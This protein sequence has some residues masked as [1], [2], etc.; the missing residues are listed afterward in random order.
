[1]AITK[2]Q[3]PTLRHNVANSGRVAWLELFFDL[4]YVAALI[5]LGDQLSDDVSWSGATRFVGMFVVLLWTWTGTSAF[6]N[7]FV[8]YAVVQL[9]LDSVQ[10][11][12]VGKLALVAVAPIENRWSW[13]VVA[14]VPA[15][16]PLLIMYVRTRNL[17][18]AS[19]RLSNLYMASFGTGVAIWIVSLLVPTPARF[20]FWAVALGIE[21]LAPIVDARRADPPPTHVEHFAERYALFTIIV[22]GESFVK[23]LSELAEVGVSAESQV[24]GLFTFAVT[25]GI[26]WTYFDDIA[27][28]D[29]RNAVGRLRHSG[30][31]RVIW[32]YNW[33]TTRGSSHGVKADDA[34]GRTAT[35]TSL[36]AHPEPTGA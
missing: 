8:S 13:L 10:M 29:L 12:A 24:F 3:P 1:V 18:A 20:A 9:G 26:W 31:I 30:S 15:R 25:V 23:I 2:W 14:F 4:I 6:L 34:A 21:F 17:D 7:L 32:V 22:L 28:S 5:Q 33:T 27:G 36:S 11:C 35:Q 19:R 16:L